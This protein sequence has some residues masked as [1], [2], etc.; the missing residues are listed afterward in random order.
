MSDILDSLFHIFKSSN[1]DKSDDEIKAQID[2]LQASPDQMSEVMGSLPKGDQPAMTAPD[3][4]LNFP[5]ADDAKSSFDVNVSDNTATMD[6]RPESVSNGGQDAPPAPELPLPAAAAPVVAPVAPKAPKV[7]PAAPVAEDPS[8]KAAKDLVSTPTGLDK[9][10][11]DALDAAERRKHNL[12]VIPVAAAGIGDAISNA[13]SAFGAQGTSG[14]QAKVA[15]GL[16]KSEDKNKA[17]FETGLKNDPSSDLSRQYQSIIS[18]VL[19]QA[20]MNVP[21]EAV[22]KMSANQIEQQFPQ[23]AKLASTKMEADGHKS[24][25]KF[26]H[27]SLQNERDARRGERQDKLKIDIVGKFNADSGVR[28]IDSSIDAANTIRGLVTSGNP[29]AAASVPTF[30]ARASG[31]VGNLSEADKAP[32]GGSRALMA[33][34]EAAIK[35]QATGKLTAENAKFITSLADT[36]E[37]RAKDNKNRR[38]AQWADQYSKTSDVFDRDD[39]Y[40]TLSPGGKPAPAAGKPAQ[41]PMGLF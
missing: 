32:F 4:S 7:A 28:K 37:N 36:M 13:A 41:D 10:K 21:P 11:R 14:T 17:D 18:K 29:I 15:E 19:E 16:N 3:M 27:D 1:P 2:N 8:T 22:A 9:A 31:E 25:L 12:G 5:P 40:N 23:L 39:L 6:G 20:G 38:A 26:R 30:M 24:D 34:L 33:R 35:Q